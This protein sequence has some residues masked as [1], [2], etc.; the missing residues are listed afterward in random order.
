MKFRLF[1]ETLCASHHHQKDAVGWAVTAN[2]AVGIW[3]SQSWA[4]QRPPSWGL[5]GVPNQTLPDPWDCPHNHI[6]GAPY[7]ARRFSHLP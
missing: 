5:G 7:S 4:Q 3:P 2:R 6:L 1:L